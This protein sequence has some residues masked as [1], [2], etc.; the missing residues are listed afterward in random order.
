MVLGVSNVLKSLDLNA[1][2][3]ADTLNLVVENLQN[4][5]R[6]EYL[7]LNGSFLPIIQISSLVTV[8]IENS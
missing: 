3:A 5:L 1:P 8:Y 2:D 6:P 7:G 4:V